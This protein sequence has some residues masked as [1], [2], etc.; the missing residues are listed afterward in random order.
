MTGAGGKGGVRQPKVGVHAGWRSEEGGSAGTQR[1]GEQK[2]E[3]V[4]VIMNHTLP[5]QEKM[6]LRNG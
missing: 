5:C 2:R 4:S 3:L 6:H 1:K